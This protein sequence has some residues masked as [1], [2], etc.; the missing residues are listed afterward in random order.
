ML[1]YKFRKLSVHAAR[2]CTV[3]F[4][5]CELWLTTGIIAVWLWLRKQQS[6]MNSVEW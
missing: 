2:I 5:K 6:E 1:M 4:S 3:Q